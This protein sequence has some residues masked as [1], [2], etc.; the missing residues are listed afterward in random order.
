MRVCLH[1]C[2]HACMRNL[3]VHSKLSSLISRFMCMPAY[4]HGYMYI[5]IYIYMYVGVYIYAHICIYI[6]VYDYV[7]VFMYFSVCT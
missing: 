3:C 2:L 7:Y 6:Y 4:T 5:R 1:A